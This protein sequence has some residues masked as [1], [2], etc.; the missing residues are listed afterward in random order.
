MKK[1]FIT[2]FAIGLV[3]L[4]FAQITELNY[5]NNVRS[6]NIH[7]GTPPSGNDLTVE[8]LSSP[9]QHHVPSPSQDFDIIYRVHNM[10]SSNSS[11]P[12]TAGIY[13][14]LDT[15]YSVDDILIK[16]DNI[17]EINTG[18]FYELT[19]T[20]SIP[21]GYQLGDYLYVLIVSNPSNVLSV[22]NI[23]YNAVI[24]TFPNPILEEINIQI[25]Q[26]NK[27]DLIVEII[28]S[29]GQ[30]TYRKNITN[31]TTSHNISNVSK[32]IY[33]LNIVDKSGNIIKS[34]KILKE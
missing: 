2:L 19:S 25:D 17:P 31:R 29:N 21:G 11:P 24:T 20:I 23:N 8:G 14:S 26:L 13:V 27:I 7:I 28:N 34:E 5:E 30:L 16:E 33:L 22:T 3:N 6:F 18:D 32:G 10:G 12:S 1:I 15:E 4:S 9:Y